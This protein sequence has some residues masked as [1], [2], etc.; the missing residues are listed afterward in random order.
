MKEENEI[1]KSINEKWWRRYTAIL[2]NEA[3]EKKWRNEMK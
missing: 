1:M 3:Y 2:M